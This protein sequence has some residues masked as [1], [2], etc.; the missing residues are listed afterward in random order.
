MLSIRCKNC[1]GIAELNATLGLKSS[2]AIIYASNGTFKTSLVETIDD[3]TKDQKPQDFFHPGK[4]SSFSIEC[5]GKK[6]SG[7]CLHVVSRPDKLEGCKFFSTSM[8]ASPSIK[9]RLEE[10]KGPL[11]EKKKLLV[12]AMVASLKAG[13][14]RKV[15]PSDVEAYVRQCS[16][17]GSFFDGLRVLRDELGDGVSI[18]AIE[19]ISY[20]ELFSIQKRKLLEKPS[21]APQIAAYEKHL[22]ALLTNTHYFV[23]GFSYRE[24]SRLCESLAGT[25]FFAAGH[26]LLFCDQVTKADRICESQEDLDCLLQ[27]ELSLVFSTKTMR[28][29]FDLVGKAL[30][31]A[32]PAQELIGYLGNHKQ[33]LG[34]MANLKGFERLFY[35][36]AVSESRNLMDTLLD[37]YDARK[38]ELTSI[39]RDIERE[40]S[41]WSN[42]IDI[43]QERF[44]FPFRI[45]M[46]N[47]VESVLG[48][49]APAIEYEH[50]DTAVEESILYEHL[51]TGE[52]N[53]M[54]LLNTIF[55]I[56]RI[57]TSYGATHYLFFDDPVDSFDYRNKYAFIEY[58]RDF[59]KK[60]GIKIIV[61]T[62]NY[63]FMRALA[64][65]LPS[66]FCRDDIFVCEAASSGEL[67]LCRSD[68]LK[69]NVLDA[70]KQ[71]VEQDNEL[72]TLAS[73]PFVR[74]LVELREGRNAEDYKLMSQALHGRTEGSLLTIDS[75]APA[76]K[77][78]WASLPLSASY[79]IQDKCFEKCE[80]LAGLKENADNLL[81]LESKIVL[82]MGSRILAERWL[83]QSR[84]ASSGAEQ[85]SYGKL[86]GRIKAHQK[87]DLAEWGIDEKR[88]KTLDEVALLTPG[89]IH[90][91]A[92]MYEPIIDTS[93][94]RLQ[95]LFL[96]C[97]GMSSN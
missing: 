74:E 16:K 46:T 77:S 86:W 25:E 49:E 56:E 91:N 79:C 39:V 90:V 75:L 45:K 28:E 43:F 50:R 82:S 52:R 58:L 68:Y 47:R 21:V 83:Y 9:A 62:H 93:A 59:A 19:G 64:T 87:K 30:G 72:V 36:R 92:F 6:I 35:L 95:D 71:E 11:S 22:D 5:D 53:A 24:L 69:K 20:P 26:K 18:E 14:K 63:D 51:S 60:T 23:T 66:V 65:R 57:P 42:A 7:A 70:W 80:L 54:F 97:Q 37:G 27:E 13:S 40:K 1:R 8:L 4:D 78:Y 67:S 2:G 10:I 15:D 89:N 94:W 96:Q 33:A 55:E 85:C 88:Y 61:L 76:Y 34:D 73:I 48:Y 29:Q 17:S 41:D 12:E 31:N 38:A 81:T 84:A 3:Y 44:S 32:K